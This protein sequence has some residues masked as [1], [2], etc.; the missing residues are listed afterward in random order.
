M[1]SKPSLSSPCWVLGGMKGVEARK[2]E[3]PWGTWLSFCRLVPNYLRLLVN[4]I[5]SFI[6]KPKNPTDHLHIPSCDAFLVYTRQT[7][8]LIPGNG[9]RGAHVLVKLTSQWRNAKCRAAARS[10]L[11]STVQYMKLAEAPLS[12]Q[13]PGASPICEFQKFRKYSSSPWNEQY[14]TSGYSH[15]LNEVK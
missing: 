2:A 14:N 4:E 9:L 5:A 3:H 12:G 1:I 8:S 10:K 6:P 11:N 15:V 13:L 7:A